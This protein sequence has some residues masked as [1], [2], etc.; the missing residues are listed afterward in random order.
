MD[1]CG[2]LQCK[3]AEVESFS[4]TFTWNFL[5]DRHD[6]YQTITSR[7]NPKDGI[8]RSNILWSLVSNA[9]WRSVKITLVRRPESKLLDILSVK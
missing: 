9:F 2:T 1:P 3:S 6:L 7:E 4:W 5:L 8:F